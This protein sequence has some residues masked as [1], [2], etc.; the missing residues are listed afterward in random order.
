MA[1]VEKWRA[2]RPYV[3]VVKRHPTLDDQWVAALPTG[4]TLTAPI[5]FDDDGDPVF[6]LPKAELL[7]HV[8]LRDCDPTDMDFRL[9][10]DGGLE[11]D[12]GNVV[13]DRH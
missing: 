2:K 11:I 4:A 6:S 3:V 5:R 12:L 8:A 7:A 9:F 1:Q 10:P 13:A